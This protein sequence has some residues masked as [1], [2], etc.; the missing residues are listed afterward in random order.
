VSTD[1]WRLLPDLT[2]REIRDRLI[3]S[4]SGWLWLV[5]TP[6]MLLAVYGFVFGVIFN[7]RVPENLDMPFVAWLAVALWPWLAFSEGLLRGSQ[8]ILA[9][10]GLISKV[11]I[12]RELLVLSS[13]SAVFALH[14]IGYAVVLIA[15]QFL[16][17]ELTWSGLPYVLLVLITLYL[18]GLGLGL[19][20][21]ALQVF[22]RDLEQILPTLVVFWFFMTPIIYAIEI[23]PA[24]MAWW[25]QFNPMTWWVEEIRAGLFIG[26]WLP[27]LAFVGLLAG[28][29][30]T[31]WAGMAVF[32]R[33][34]P[35]FEDFL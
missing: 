18:F 22:V 10:S 4:S 16:G 3:N 25:L 12:P 27:D 26:K 14:M 1:W 2:R 5:V 20:L 8:S 7:A 9:N 21:A 35:S 30:L 15:I 33:L 28:A 23:I 31:L 17:T 34:S 19:M 24:R 13:Q 6:L 32:K 11:A 29:L